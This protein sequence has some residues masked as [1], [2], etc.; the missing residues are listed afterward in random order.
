MSNRFSKG[1][2]AIIL[3]AVLM[4]I[5]DMPDSFK[6]TWPDNW[7][8]NIFKKPK[9]T[10]GLDLQG[11][12]QLDYRI[13]LRNVNAKNNDAD[14]KND[15]P[16]NDIVEGVRATIE[17]R[18][19]GLGVSEPQI[20]LSKVGDEQHIIVELAGV[21]DV[22]QAKAIVGKTIQLEFKEKKTELDA[23][24]KGKI[25]SEA[26]AVLDKALV[27]GSNFDA[28]GKQTDAGEKSIQYRPDK[29]TYVSELPAQY[30]DIFP[31]MKD[32]EVYKNV[33]EGSDGY[34]VTDGGQLSETKGLYV[35][36]LIKSA[37]ADH[38]KKVTA[39]LEDVA[40]EFGKTVETL[41]GKTKKDLPADVAD[42]IWAM[43]GENKTYSDIIESKDELGIY[44][45]VK[46]NPE[47]D[48]I[49]ASHILIAYKGAQRAG[50]DVT[51]TKDEAKALADKLLAQV[52]ASPDKF[53]DIA[54]ANTD[55]P[56]GKT[57]G[58]DLGFFGKGQMTKA[59]EVAAFS[60][61]TGDISD[62]VE[63]EFGYH[64]IKDTDKKTSSESAD[65]QLLK[66]KKS[67]VDR[68]KLE[69]AMKKTQGYD[70]TTKEQQFEYNE[71]FFDLTP[72]P[73]KSTGLDGSHFKMASLSYDQLGAPEVNIQF[74]S[75]GGDMF[76][77]ITGRLVGK[78]LA[79][80]VGGQLISAPNVNQK[81]SG[82]NAVITGRYSIQEA[83]KLANDLNTG[84]I[85]APII[86]AGQSTISAT[87]GSTALNV[88]LLAGIIGLIAL[89]LFMI[90]YYRLLGFIAILALTIY[91]IIII[92]VIKTT[93]IVMTLA[94]IAGIILSIG[95]AVDA[96]IL[97]FARTKEELEGGKNFS[98][99]ITAGFER[100]WLSIR[101]SNASS[102]ITC[103]IL[104]FF[105]NSII[106]GFALMLALGI[107]VSLFT[108]ITVTRKFLHTIIGTSLVKNRFLLGA[109]EVETINR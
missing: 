38:T 37:I 16:V 1:L 56:T 47:G 59:F 49:R 6:A 102:L 72:D 13:D 108:A 79:I 8:T 26:Q 4:A 90:L 30:K 85:D 80:F 69:E 64:I 63:T 42:I 3:A 28:I 103:T 24:E 14:P 101:D 74:D 71:I 86:L 55:D 21:K 19:N 104:W 88:S 62:V 12:T 18:V 100:A 10:L 39:T 93:G 5:V 96:N 94:G 35:V 84:A 68:A 76:E 40:K 87:L 48:Q 81:I 109:E 15:V 2:I 89:A 92:F 22:E 70:V 11:G 46:F 66:F 27:V 91:S 25:Q 75:A 43:P 36:Q 77:E 32:G 98:A 57:T 78:P 45:L 51:R 23:N 50:A 95:M 106:R 33:I 53:A 9:V 44:K 67:E 54:K 99:A 7:F 17:R 61:N 107:L 73:W 97:I 20:Y 31:K 60:M 105:G 65:L 29:K 58:G 34:T 83:M 82:G 52:K 41:N